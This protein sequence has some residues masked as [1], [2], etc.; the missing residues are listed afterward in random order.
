MAKP[1]PESAKRT[2]ED[3]EKSAGAESPREFSAETNEQA[4]ELAIQAKDLRGKAKT[5]EDY[6]ELTKLYKE[7][8]RLYSPQELPASMQEQY[9]KQ[10]ELMQR[11]GVV[12]S[13]ESGEFGIEGIDGKEY[14][15]PTPEQVNQRIEEGKELVEKKN[16]QGFTKL[17]LVPFGMKLKDLMEAYKKSILAHGASAKLFSAKKDQAVQNEQLVPLALDKNQPLYDWDGYDEADINGKLVY[18]PKEFSKNHKGKTKQEI[19]KEQEKE[20]TTPGW[21]IILIED[22]PDIP[23]EN[24]GKTIGGRK[25][26]EANDTP[27]N[28]LKTLR[29]SKKDNP[30]QGEEGMTPEDQLMYAI[31]HLEETDQVIDDYQGNGSI[32]YQVGAYFPASGVVP[33]ACWDRGNRRAVLGRYYPDNRYDCCGV[34]SAVRI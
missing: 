10:V 30:Y 34:R 15:M 23:R 22:M 32:S 27:N 1:K 20:S 3:E 19:L 17:L 13:L 11:L 7:I 33:S 29:D 14:P 5:A 8:E 25:Q 4:K 9:E 26:F 6:N 21:H 2:I 12:K 28:Y 24:K 18:Q 16:E 31:T